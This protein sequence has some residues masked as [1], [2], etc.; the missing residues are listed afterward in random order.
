M[1]YFGEDMKRKTQNK[2]LVPLLLV[3]IGTLLLLGSV[4]IFANQ[5]E[6]SVVEA[7][8]TKTTVSIPFPQVKRVSLVDAKAAYDLGNAVF[9]DTRGEPYY[10][11]GHIPGAFSITD[12]EILD[13]LNQFDKNAWII[14]YCT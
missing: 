1:S 8:P 3:G 13:Q 7:L 6:K 4:I 12:S 14:T 9:I 2:K 10:S 5:P 11:Q